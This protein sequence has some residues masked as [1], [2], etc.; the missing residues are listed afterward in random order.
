MKLIIAGGGTGGHIN[1]AIAVANEFVKRDDNN[2]VLFIGTKKGLEAQLIPKAGFLIKYIEVEGF[3]Q[4]KSFY[5]FVVISKLVKSIIKCMNIIRKEKPDIV[6]G[7]GGY[8]SAPVVLAAHILKIPTLILEQNIVA[9]KTTRLLSKYVDRICTAFCGTN[10]PYPEKITVTGNPIRKGFTGKDKYESKEKLGLTEDIPFVLCV[11][12][13][14]GAEKISECMTKFIINNHK[15]MEYYLLIVTGDL[16]YEDVLLEL[17][18]TNTD[19]KNSRIFIKNYI[20]NMEDYMSAADVVISRSG[21]LFLSEIAY[22][23]KPSLLI[24]S[25]NV[26]EN[27][28][29]KNADNYVKHNAAIKISEKDLTEHSLKEALDKLLK[30]KEKLIEMEK[31]AKSMSTPDSSKKIV[32][33]MYELI[34]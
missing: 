30:N 15:N 9:G 20:D 33:I 31:A 13:S 8:V 14:L 4:K 26:S 5:N 27:H 1:P 28:Q 3:L 17:K 10:I 2:S 19:I 12:G 11:S 25:P 23:G 29:E 18:R 7:T 6:V 16:Y 34:C 21:A 24:P 32:D 22:L